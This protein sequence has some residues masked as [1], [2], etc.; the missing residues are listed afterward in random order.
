VEYSYSGSVF[1]HKADWPHTQSFG[2]LLSRTKNSCF[3]HTP[4][5]VPRESLSFFFMQTRLA[6]PDINSCGPLCVPE[7]RSPC[8][9]GPKRMTCEQVPGPQHP[10]VIIWVVG[11]LLLNRILCWVGCSVH[12]PT[13][14]GVECCGRVPAWF[15]TNVLPWWPDHVSEDVTFATITPRTDEGFWLCCYTLT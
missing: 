1:T 12:L 14:D 3:M 11:S 9:F 5:K 7:T 8:S 13:G 2:D 15:V 6:R 4:C 10:P